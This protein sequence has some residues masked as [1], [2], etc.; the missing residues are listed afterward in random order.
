M[1]NLR[2]AFAERDV[3]EVEKSGGE[4]SDEVMEQIC[5]KEREIRRVRSENKSKLLINKNKFFRLII[6]FFGRKIKAK[7]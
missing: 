1:R 3:I 7:L 2:A 5:E 4:V 6:Q